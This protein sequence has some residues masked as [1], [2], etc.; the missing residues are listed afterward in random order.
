MTPARLQTIEEIFYRAVEKEPDEV[1]AF[2]DTACKG[3]EL[4]RRKVESLLTS[5]QRSGSFIESPAAGITP[6]IIANGQADLLVGQTFGHYQ[7]S[8][9]IGSGGM[10]EVNF[11]TNGKRGPKARPKPLPMRFTEMPSRRKEFQQ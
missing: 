7:I 4:L 11:P 10:A 5:Y 6:R 2:L 1:S 8:K 3:D 9:R